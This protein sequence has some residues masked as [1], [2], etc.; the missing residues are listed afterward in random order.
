MKLKD[1]LINDEP[2]FDAF[3]IGRHQTWL[4]DWMRRARQTDDQWLRAMYVRYARDN[5]EK[6]MQH[7]RNLNRG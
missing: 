1:R 2:L 3:M 7:K 6:L 4:E 5:H